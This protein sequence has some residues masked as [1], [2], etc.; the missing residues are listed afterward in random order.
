MGL[1]LLLL[2]ILAKICSESLRLWGS[3]FCGLGLMPD[4][5]YYYCRL[6]RKEFKVRKLGL[7]MEPKRVLSVSPKFIR[8]LRWLLLRWLDAGGFMILALMSLPPLLLLFCI[9]FYFN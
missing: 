3:K 6:C 7:A 8:L 4:A 9:L 5:A 2:D 1:W